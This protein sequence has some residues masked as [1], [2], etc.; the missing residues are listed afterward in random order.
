MGWTRRDWLAGL[1]GF[2]G[3]GA[4]SRLLSSAAAPPAT[5]EQNAPQGQ[6]YMPQRN[7]PLPYTK[8]Q[9]PWEMRRG[10]KVWPNGA[11]MAV[12]SYSALEMWD[13]GGP[14]L[15]AVA[16]RPNARSFTNLGISPLDARTSVTYGADIGCRRLKEVL[17]EL[18]IEKQFV[19]L[20][21]GSF[22][23]DFPEQV[24]ALADLG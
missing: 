14:R 1:G 12:I 4:G 16:G 6:V 2:A 10:A 15:Q 23:E 8:K 20:V 11:R 24:K 21:C 7:K 3:L 9:M 19:A 17:Q 5:A 13:W 18:G 22:A